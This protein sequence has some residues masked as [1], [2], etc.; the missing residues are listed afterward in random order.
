MIT[1]RTRADY[2]TKRAKLRAHK[3]LSV[4]DWLCILVL[5]GLLS[6][7][8]RGCT[9]FPPPAKGHTAIYLELKP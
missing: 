5:A 3:R 9:E 1:E 7:T 4:T 8:V 6:V 2:V